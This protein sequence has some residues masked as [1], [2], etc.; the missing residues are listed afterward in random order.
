KLFEVEEVNCICVDWKKGSQATY[1]Q[2]ANNVRVVGAQV[3]QML[4]ILL[5]EY[6]YPPSKVHLIGHSLGAHVAGEAG[7]KTPGLSRIT[8]L[9][10]VEASFE[11]TPE[12]VRLDPS[13]ADFVDV[14]HTDAAP[15]IPFLGFGTNQQMGHLDFFPNGGESMPGCK[16]NALSQI[17]D[18]DGIWAGQVLPVSRSRMPTDGSL[19]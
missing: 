7:S 8:G 14:I 13:D 12:E 1:T 3:A 11:S 18:L 16:K 5:T 4:D 9:D 19:C 10:P 15:L 6:S 17:V 2:A